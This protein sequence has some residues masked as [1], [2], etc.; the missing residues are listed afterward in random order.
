MT[1]ATT[2]RSNETTGDALL[3]RKGRMIAHSLVAGRCPICGRKISVQCAD[4][5]KRLEIDHYVAHAAGGSRHGN[6]IAMCG[7]CNASKGASAISEWLPGRLLRLNLASTLRG[8]RRSTTLRLR[9]LEALRDE[10]TAALIAAG[11]WA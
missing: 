1:T 7:S 3:S 8:A 5:R 6:L 2:K 4:R 10:L 11:I 9:K